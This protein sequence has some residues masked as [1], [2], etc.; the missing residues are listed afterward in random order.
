MLSHLLY[1]S[2]L[3]QVLLCRC[4]R[5]VFKVLVGLIQWFLGSHHTF[6][7]SHSQFQAANIMLGVVQCQPRCLLWSSVHT[8]QDI[9]VHTELQ[10]GHQ[11]LSALHSEHRWL[12]MVFVWIT[13]DLCH[14]RN[15]RLDMR[16]MLLLLVQLQHL[17]M[18]LAIFLSVPGCHRIWL[19]RQPSLQH[20]KSHLIACLTIHCH[21]LLC[22]HPQQL[23]VVWRLQVNSS[24]EFQL[25]LSLSKN[26]CFQSF[27]KL[28][29]M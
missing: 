29:F 11:F 18:C 6:R 5:L 27:S 8:L 13:R 15:H 26:S 20:L 19:L 14:C 10:C 16:V 3:L 22:R 17:V 9:T 7:T 2:P 4:Y 28:F 1:Q 21:C 23:D 25:L 12:T 24:D